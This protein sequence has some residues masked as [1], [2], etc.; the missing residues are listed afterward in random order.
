MYPEPMVFSVHGGEASV[1]GV[2][3]PVVISF[4]P[5]W[6]EAVKKDASSFI[7][8]DTKNPFSIDAMKAS[9]AAVYVAKDGIFSF[10]NDGQLQGEPYSKDANYTLTRSQVDEFVAKAT[11]WLQY[12]KIVLL[13][14][15]F[16]GILL[17]VFV[18]YTIFAFLV[19][20]PVLAYYAWFL[21]N[22]IPYFQAYRT[23]IYAMTLPLVLYEA[24][25][26]ANIPFSI[27]FAFT[28]LTVAVVAWNTFDHKK[29]SAHA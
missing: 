14:L 29:H 17:G 13:A 1:T 25:S 28:C 2:E 6:G 19:A 8:I 15:I 21:K 26:L 27:P 16:I 5:E 10:K 11:P 18:G 22:P 20:L 4:P 12:A 9:H 7:V 23:T 24:V 3:E